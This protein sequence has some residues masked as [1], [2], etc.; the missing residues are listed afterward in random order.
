MSVRDSD[1]ELFVPLAATL[2]RYGFTIYATIGT[3]TMLYNAGIKTRA[4]YRI[5]RGRPNVL[6]LIRD[7]E[8]NWIINTSESGATPMLDETQ[9]R[10]QA[11]AA[12]IPITTTAS[13][14]VAA[15][16][17][18][19]EKMAFGR[20]EVYSLQEYQL[21][22]TRPRWTCSS[23]SSKRPYC[24]MRQAIGCSKP[25]TARRIIARRQ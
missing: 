18:L 12:G 17:G 15:I 13:G 24:P 14:A 9:M 4:V 1:K 19:E 3:S 5:S 20:Y 6:D 7:R 10:S 23:L 22:L 16:G 8:I 11:V 21:V 2:Q 25:L